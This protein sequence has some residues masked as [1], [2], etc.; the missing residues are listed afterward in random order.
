MW[1]ALKQLN[2]LYRSNIGADDSFLLHDKNNTAIC[3]PSFA[4]EFNSFD[5]FKPKKIENCRYLSKVVHPRSDASFQLLRTPNE[6]IEDKMF[7]HAETE[8]QILLPMFAASV[9]KRLDLFQKNLRRELEIEGDEDVFDVNRAFIRHR[10]GGSG[11]SFSTPHQDSKDKKAF[12][13]LIALQDST[14]LTLLESEHGMYKSCIL[15]SAGDAILFQDISWHKSPEF[16]GARTVALIL[17]EFNKEFNKEHNT[18][19][20]AT[21]SGIDMTKIIEALNY[22]AEDEDI[23]DIEDSGEEDEK[24]F[25]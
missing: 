1:T 2:C 18:N 8:T 10:P 22:R 14:P 16:D 17:C 21:L 6:Y 13:I 20:L 4:R 15:R 24:M 19:T 12:T 23:E 9:Q 25:G 7:R 11:D 3:I 5:I